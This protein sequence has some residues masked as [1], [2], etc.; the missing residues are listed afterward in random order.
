[1]AGITSSIA[2]CLSEETSIP[3]DRYDIRVLRAP[4]MLERGRQPVR[5]HCP[6][7]LFRHGK[8]FVPITLLWRR[9]GSLYPIGCYTTDRTG[10]TTGSAFCTNGGTQVPIL[11]YLILII[12]ILTARLPSRL[13]LISPNLTSSSMALILELRCIP[14]ISV[15]NTS[16]PPVCSRQNASIR[17]VR[18]NRYVFTLLDRRS[19][20][21]HGTGSFTQCTLKRCL[22]F[23]FPL[24]TVDRSRD[25]ASL[26]VI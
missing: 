9:H 19:A 8:S 10:C 15:D 17:I 23:F 26:S 7:I 6:H 12:I 20:L 5:E 14:V 18:A 24:P 16:S 2:L 13:I 21:T 1:M 25:R 11:S 22:L 4:S 3:L